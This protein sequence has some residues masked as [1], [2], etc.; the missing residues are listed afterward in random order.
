MGHN[1]EHHYIVLYDNGTLDSVVMDFDGIRSLHDELGEDCPSIV[2]L[3]VKDVPFAL[4][5]DE[6]RKVGW[7]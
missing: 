1:A 6:L 4:N 5:A 2:H 7:R 3:L